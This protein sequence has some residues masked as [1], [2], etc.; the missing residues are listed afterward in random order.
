M[1]TTTR[2]SGLRERFSLRAYSG[3]SSSAI[4]LRLRVGEQRVELGQLGELL[5]RAPHHPDRLAAP[6][7]GELLARL[8]AAD[9]DLDRG[10]GG[11]GTLRRLKTA[12]EGDGDEAGTDCAGTT[13]RDDPGALATVDLLLT[14]ADPFLDD[15]RTRREKSTR[16][17]SGAVKTDDPGPGA[18]PLLDFAEPRQYSGHTAEDSMGLATE[19]REFAAKGN[20]VDLAVGVII[21]AAFGKIVDSL[22]EGHHHAV[23]GR[24]FG[25]PR[26]LELL[27]RPSA[28]PPARAMP[29]R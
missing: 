8:D 6:F 16:H 24:I 10:A 17:S 3:V 26:L 19:F 2:Y 21:G 28:P 7:D 25:G 1:P 27:R 22:V 13:R 15:A 11:A 29:D 18:P 14:H 23:I 9:V 12:D 4:A 20:V 5:G